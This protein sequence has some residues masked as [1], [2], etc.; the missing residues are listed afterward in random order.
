MPQRHAIAVLCALVVGALAAPTAAGARTITVDSGRD[1]LADDGTCTLREAVIAANED[2]ASGATPGECPSGSGADEIDVDVP[3]VTLTIPGRDETASRT[4]DLDAASDLTLAGAGQDRTTID[5]AGIDRVLEVLSGAPVTVRDLTITGGVT[6]D[7]ADRPPATDG[8]RGLS[9]GSGGIGDGQDVSSPSAATGD[10]KA[11][12]GGDGGP[13]GSGAGIFSAGP[14]TVIDSVFEGNVTGPGGAGG[15]ATGGT[16]GAGATGG[17]ATSGRGGGGGTGAGLFALGTVTITHSSFMDNTTG[18]GGFGGQAIAGDGGDGDGGRG[19]RGG[20]ALSENGGPGGGGGGLALSGQATMTDV[21]V[22]ANRTGRGGPSDTAR[23]GSGGAPDTGGGGAG[24]QAN[25]GTGGPGGDGGGVRLLN[26]SSLTLTGGL[27]ATGSGADAGDAFGGVGANGIAGSG[28]PGGSAGGGAGG[29]GG[30]GAGIAAVDGLAADS[31]TVARNATGAGGSG[32]SGFGLPGGKGQGGFPGGDGGDGQGGDGGPGGPGA[33]VV[34]GGELTHVTVAGNTAS[35]AGGPPGE[36][37]GGIGGAGSGGTPPGDSGTATPGDAGSPGSPGGLDGGRSLSSLRLRNAIVSANTP[38][39]CAQ[40]TGLGGDI[41]FPDATCPGALVADPLLTTLA[42][43][44]GVTPTFA[45][46][47]G[48]P[49]IDAVP[50]TGAGCDATDQR[51]VTRPQG[52]ACD[53]G[54]YEVAPPGVRTDP[55]TVA[56]TAVRL[57]ATVNP[58]AQDTT[59]R[60]EFGLTTAY[61]SRTARIDPGDGT[62][63]TAVTALLT[64]L[65]DGTTFHYRVLA[66]NGDG[67]S[68][69]ADRTFRTPSS[70]TGG[71]PPTGGGG[72]TRPK[73]SHL[74]LRPARFRPVTRRH[75]RHRGTRI[76]YRDSVAGRTTFAVQRRRAHARHGKRF[77][78]LRGRFHHSHRAGAVHLHWSGRLRG[79]ALKPGVYRLLA[80]PAH[81]TAVAKRFRIRR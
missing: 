80:R 62:A 32:G 31:D 48:S 9:G 3:L 74:R 75:H 18:T 27:I 15:D 59:V 6:A 8:G 70:P 33:G 34:A 1:V 60:F 11:A 38:S 46:Q 13:G 23:G 10:A 68:T 69:G 42:S 14:L 81:G 54:A 4:G 21:S 56:G 20:A 40:V 35:P 55:A 26:I 66:T 53:A 43:H 16:G 5:A 50:A 2:T 71:P 52:P 58:N 44:G 64:G 63:G 25:A 28:G 41:A 30:F 78:R 22:T 73:L 49:A 24:G 17:D 29:R 51:G 76:S 47:A 39:A 7:G 37:V 65:P 79:R 77:V 57:R 72:S 19:G 36:G 12:T 45:L 61:G 67:S